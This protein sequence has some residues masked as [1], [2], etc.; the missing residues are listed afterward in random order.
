ML[1]RKTERTAE[2]ILVGIQQ[3]FSEREKVSEELSEG[4]RLLV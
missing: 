3:S 2:L 1:R 4:E